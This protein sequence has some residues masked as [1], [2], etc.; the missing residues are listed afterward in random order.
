MKK[1]NSSQRSYLK[2]QAHHLNPVVLI[3]KSGL[4][5]GAID[6]INKALDKRELIKIKFRDFKDNKR[7]LSEEITMKTDS[8]LVSIIGHTLIIFKENLNSEKRHLKL[9]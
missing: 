1:I 7:S 8:I 3:G 9:P 5:D 4:N 2:S 6:L